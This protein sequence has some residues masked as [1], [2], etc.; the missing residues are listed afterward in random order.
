VKRLWIVDHLETS[1]DRH[2]G[3]FALG[4]TPVYGHLFGQ[5]DIARRSWPAAEYF[6]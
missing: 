4:D 5:G 2:A 6:A 1:I 3:L